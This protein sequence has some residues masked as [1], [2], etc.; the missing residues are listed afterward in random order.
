MGTGQ[1]RSTAGVD[2]LRRLWQSARQGL[3]RGVWMTAQGFV[4][5]GDVDAIA[6]TDAAALDNYHV[7]CWNF[8]RTFL[9]PAA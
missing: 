5:P 6:Q 3:D 7:T 4:V 8:Q 2:A 1:E 9:Q